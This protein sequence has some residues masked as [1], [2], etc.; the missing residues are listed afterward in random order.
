MN[1]RVRLV[2]AV[3][4]LLAMTQ[5]AA[6][7]SGAK[8][9]NE[10]SSI[11]TVPTS[12]QVLL[13]TFADRPD[14]ATVDARLAGLGAVSESVPEIGIWALAPRRPATARAQVLTRRQVARAEWSMLR[15]TDDLTDPRPVPP[16]PLPLLTTAEP[17][18]P[19]YAVADTNQQ[20][21][22]HR[23]NWT[24]GLSGY[25]RPTIAILDSGIAYTHEEWRQPG[26]LV[27]PRSTIYHV[28]RAEDDSELGHGTHVAGIA[29]APANGVGIVGVAPASANPALPGVSKVMPVQI[30]DSQ[31]TSQ[32]STMIAGIRWAVN[33]GAKVINIS[34]GGPGASNAFQDTVNWAFKRGALVIA[35]VGNEGLA[36]PINP[37][38]VNLVNFPAGYDHVIGVGALCDGFV[39]PPDCPA[40]F[41]RAR[42][43]N[44][45]Y[46]VDVMAPGVNIL[47][48]L[49]LAVQ[50]GFVAP[51]YG[52]KSGTSMAAPYVAGVVALI[53]ASH[54]GIT[55]YQVTRIL[56]ATSGGA[57][58][59]YGRSRRFGW[60]A[61]NPLLAAQA[62]APVD[63]LS[64]INDDVK[65]LPQRDTMRL[66]GTPILL[67][68]RM[69]Y[70]D[71]QFDTYA[72]QLRKGERMK[73]T[74]VS[75]HAKIGL[76][77]YRPGT[78]SVV[79]GVRTA[80][81]L[82][83]KRL[84]QIR[85]PTPGTRTVVVRAKQTGRHFIA[86]DALAGGDDYTLVIRRA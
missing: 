26:L 49:P 70:N 35:S 30:T 22:L 14:H 20:W 4:A 36:D 75:Q 80:E 46:T 29:A 3:F 59:G 19:Y 27:S 34:S 55:P 71:D 24:P 83:A 79:L 12:G 6:A 61:V 2:V 77:V 76:T 58:A 15:T 11:G 65:W 73:V 41:G 62:Q 84:G 42:F 16:P 53:Y 86:L 63:D 23:G 1:R 28:G 5:S 9:A 85:R 18:D 56:Q 31:G 7:Q 13:V 32:D 48:T 81:Q 45:N 8:V 60:G 57:M 38:S 10:P 54:P 21:S 33:N 64:E 25:A 43:S 50:E 17:T 69:D 68:A 66:T 44:Y 82:A 78:S 39:A 47:S 37:E 52:V 40:A 51:G 67:T 72:V 74:I